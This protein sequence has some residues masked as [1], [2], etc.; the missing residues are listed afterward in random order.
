[1]TQVRALLA[2][3][4]LV[5]LTGA[6]G[7]GKTRL[8][9]EVALLARYCRSLTSTGRLTMLGAAKCSAASMLVAVVTLAIPLTVSRQHDH[10]AAALTH[11][12]QH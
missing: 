11:I 12:H 3:S 7:V 6:G 8:A 4:R 2:D 9:L 1:M 5:T 10:C